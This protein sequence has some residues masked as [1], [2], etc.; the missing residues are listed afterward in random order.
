MMAVMHVATME[1]SRTKLALIRSSKV[2]AAAVGDTSTAGAGIAATAGA[3]T[4]IASSTRASGG[5]ASAAGAGTGASA[6][7][8]IAGVAAATGTMAPAPG[9]CIGADTG[10]G[11]GGGRLAGARRGD[12]NA[13]IGGIGDESRLL[14]DVLAI[15]AGAWTAMRLSARTLSGESPEGGVERGLLDDMLRDEDGSLM[16]DLKGDSD[17]LIDDSFFL[18]DDLKGCTS[19]EGVEAEGR[20]DP[21]R[22]T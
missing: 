13:R 7:G 9:T 12:A 8:V 15:G 4:S 16:G 3:V 5:I 19:Q 2:G 20:G 22:S 14:A 21:P 18:M 11:A 6:T 17:F 1:K 10:A